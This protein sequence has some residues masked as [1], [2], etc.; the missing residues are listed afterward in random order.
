MSFEEL[1]FKKSIR[2]HK[3]IVCGFMKILWNARQLYK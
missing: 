1:G 2:E 3:I